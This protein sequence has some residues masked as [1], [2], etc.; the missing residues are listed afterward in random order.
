[1]SSTLSRRATLAA[2]ASALALAAVPKAFAQ[3]RTKLRFSSAFTEQDLRTEAYK[4]F[5][6]SI[7]DNFTFEPYWGNTLFKQGTELVALQRGNLEMCNLAPADISK[8]IPAW[9]LMTSAYL[10]RDVDHLKKTFKSDVGREFIKMARDQLGIQIIT[11]VYF[12][13]RNVNLKPT[14]EIKTPADLAGIKLRMPPGEYW[15]FLGESIGVNPTPV[16]YAE[17]YTALQSGAIDGQDNPLVASRLMKFN[18]VTT[19]FVL[20]GHVLGYDVMVI[21]TKL[22]DAMP[23][24]Q[25]AQFQAAA[26]KAIDDYTAKFVAQEKEVLDEFKKEGKKVYTPDLAAFRTYAQKK[27]VDKYGSEWPKGALERINAL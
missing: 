3:A 25:Q 2:G 22:W 13:S 27:Y 5:A 8:Q 6:A 7:K 15:Q 4:N 24:A 23:P 1:M 26:E 9:S 20:T 11:P 21:T 16:A 18:E 14:K 19:Q 12:G 17:V 10:F